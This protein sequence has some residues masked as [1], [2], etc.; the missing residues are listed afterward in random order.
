MPLVELGRL[1]GVPTPM[2]DALIDLA[3]AMLRIDFR[4]GGRTLARLGL[5]GLAPAALIHH[6]NTARTRVPI[7]V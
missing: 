6:V 4:R 1:A 7:G 5:E 3:A 2:T